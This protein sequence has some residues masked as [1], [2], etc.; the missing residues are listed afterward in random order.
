MK[1]T[2]ERRTSCMEKHELLYVTKSVCPICLKELFAEIIVKDDGIYMEKRCE[3]HGFFSTLIWA[4]SKENYLRWL[5]F[6]G[7]DVDAHPKT[8][9]EAGRILHGLNFS[10]AA[11]QQPAS[12]ALM[13]TNRCNMNCPVCFTRDQKEPLHEPSLEECGQL[14]RQYRERA[15]ED[16]LIEFCG[17][18]PTVRKDI[19]ELASLAREIGFDYIQLNT[20]GIRLAESVEFCKQLKEHGITTV[21]LGFD[22][23]TDK[24][25]FAKYGKP[26]LETKKKAVQNCEE[27]GLAV[28]LVTCVIPGE[29]DGELGRIVEYAKEHMPTVKGVYLQPI[30]YFGIYP[31]DKIRRITIPDV[32]RRLS[33]QCEEVK[34]QDF[35]PGAYDHPQCSFNACYLLD[36]SGKLRALTRMT[37]RAME[38]DAVHRLRKNLRNTWL[39]STNRM[40]TI[41]GM[42]F[43]DG[44]NIDLMR[45]R[46][47]SIQI[48]QKDGK[49]IPLCSKYLS[50][51]NGSKVF[52]GI[53]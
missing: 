25:Y 20:N 29:N 45:V 51:C 32:I 48:I 36:R 19:L 16:A 27:A 12:A 13:T 22:G 35:G 34:E 37:E 24:P 38:G 5:R 21:Y 17:G 28:V 49:L 43:Q 15:G 14:M 44:W 40:L 6:G 39:P 2:T 41:G 30:S 1:K 26:M 9:E 33:E 8:E 53:G 23:M 52:P 42:A 11:C 46:K 47:C 3:E 31:E 50:G 4:D 7:Q 10:C 18:E